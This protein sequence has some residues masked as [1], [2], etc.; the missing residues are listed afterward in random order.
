M[1]K[2][3]E[4]WKKSVY[5]KK[6]DFDNASYDCVDVSKSWIMYLTDKSWQTVAGWG[7]A[8]DIY[9]FWKDTYLEKLPA[10][11]APKLGDIAVMDGSV[12]GGY[13]HTGVVVG[14]SGNNITIY[15]QNTFT[16]QAVYT[17]V[18]NAYGSYIKYMRPKVAFT[19]GEVQLQPHQRIASYAA[20]Y[21]SEPNSG[22]KLLQE[23]V[24]GETYDFKG[25]VV[26]ENVDGNPNWFVG[27]YTGGYVWSGAF[28]DK[29]TTGLANITPKTLKPTE[30][31]VAADVMNVRRE[32]K[33]MPDNVITQLQPGTVHDFNGWIKGTAVEGN[34]VWFRLVTGGFVH[35]S[36]FTDKGTHDL[37]ALTVAPTPVEPPKPVE[38]TY[39]DL[40][41]KVIDISS[42]N[43]VTDYA[44]LKSKVRGVVAKAGHTG[45]SY[46]GIQPI[47]GDPTFP[48]HKAN[49]GDKLVGAYW[50]AYPSLDPTA[51]AQ[52]FLT[53]V[54][55]VPAT[56]TYWLDI[57]EYDGITDGAKINE[58]C[59]TFLRVVEKAIGRKCG[60]YM[61]RNWYTHI[62]KDEV[63]GERPIWLAHYDTPEMSNPVK[64]QVGHQYTSSGSAPGV[65]GKVDLNAVTNDFFIPAV[66]VEPVPTP[67]DPEEPVVVA[68]TPDPATPDYV[69][70]IKTVAVNMVVT[71]FQTFAATWAA[72]GFNLDKVVIAG[73]IGGALSLVW[74]TILKPFLI[75][76]GALKQ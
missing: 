14:I 23:F 4:T 76:K 60:L 16:Q 47:N 51:E 6:I 9:S 34:D 12:G 2:S 31:Q 10:G 18:W 25:Y 75:K 70:E 44:L 54:G 8:K 67:V 39:P 62:I 28:T 74:N 50:Y 46:G 40:S 20:K 71:F 13:G 36:G 33:L 19:I 27:A 29:S 63:K 11:S 59:L 32:A 15:Q 42:H 58:W 3:L 48:A 43:K 21:R 61:N 1:A 5:G 66:V 45:K 7:N 53:A 72:T 57:E 65:E 52:A 41:N 35:S 55:T 37:T 24:A 73:A 30:R 22:A 64:N 49:L 38:P 26:G 56:F 68:P 17:G 69:T